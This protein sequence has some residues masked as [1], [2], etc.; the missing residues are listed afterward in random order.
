MTLEPTLD[1]IQKLLML[2]KFLGM[3]GLSLAIGPLVGGLI[4]DHFNSYNGLYIGAFVIGLAAAG[5]MLTFRPA[6]PAAI[7]AT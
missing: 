2:I 7:H 5:V 3:Q 1:E 4:F 6:R